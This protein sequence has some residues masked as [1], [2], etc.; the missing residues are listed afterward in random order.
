M[1]S[2]M[3]QVSCLMGNEVMASWYL[4]HAFPPTERTM[5][6]LSRP[7]LQM[8]WNSIMPLKRL[9]FLWNFLFKM[10]LRSSV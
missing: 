6:A 1:V 2:G 5:L 3:T 10:P 4:A 9:L 8:H 7:I